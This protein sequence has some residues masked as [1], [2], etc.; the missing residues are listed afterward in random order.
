MTEYEFYDLISNESAQ[1]LVQFSL[2]LTILFAYLVSAYLVGRKLTQPQVAMLSGLFV[3][4]AGAQAWGMQ[5][6]LNRVQEILHK[7]A[8][9]FPLTEYEIGYANHVTFW[10]GAMILGLIAALIFMWQVRRQQSG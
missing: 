8:E 3:F 9:I 4:A 6:Q 10:G 1:I 7:K 2:Y 5:A